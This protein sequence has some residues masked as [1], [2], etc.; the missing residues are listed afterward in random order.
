MLDGGADQRSMPSAT[1]GVRGAAVV[2]GKS[3]AV[4]QATEGRQHSVSKISC[5]LWKSGRRGLVTLSC[6]TICS[7]VAVGVAPPVEQRFGRLGDALALSSVLGCTAS[8][9]RA[10]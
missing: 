9:G 7:I 5:L 1:F 2:P 4:K 6:W 10:P 8:G 3:I